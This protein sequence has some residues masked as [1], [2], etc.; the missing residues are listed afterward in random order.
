MGLVAWSGIRRRWVSLLFLTVALGLTGAVVLASVAGSRRGRES[1]DNFVEYYRPG[2]LQAFVDPGLPIDEQVDLLEAMIEASG[3]ADHAARAALVVYL[4]GPEGLDGPGSDGLVADAYVSGEP[5]STMRRDLVVDGEVPL[6]PG[7]AAIS[8]SL[9]RRRDL[10]VGDA[11][12]L[13]LFAPEDLD[14]VGGGTITEP[15]ESVEVT[16]GAV[17]RA[18]VDL[19]RSPQAQPGTIFEADESRIVLEPSFWADHGRASANY[20]LGATFDV[21]PAD[22]DAVS[23]AMTEAGGESSLVYPTGASDEEGRITPVNDAIALEANALLAFA[24]VVLVFGLALL[25]TALARAAGDDATDRRTLATLGLSRRQQVAMFLVRGGLVVAGA[26]VL[27]GAGAIAASSRFPIGLGGDAETDPGLDLDGSVLVLGGLAF[28]VLV[29]LRLLLGAWSD[30]RRLT[31]GRRASAPSALPLTPVGLGAR[32][33]TDGLGR[34]GGGTT[35]VALVTAVVGLAAVT[36]AATYG[37][38]LHRLVDSPERQGWTWDAV[39]GNYSG[40]PGAAEEGRAALEANPDVAAFTAYQTTTYLVDG[41]TVT[42]AEFEPGAIDLV[43]VVLEGRAPIADDEIAL[44]RGTLA[45]LGKERGDTVEVAATGQPVEATIVGVIVAPATIA[46]E[47]DLDSGGSIAF[48]L[49]ERVLADQPHN[50]VLGYLVDFVEGTD[51]AAA[52]QGLTEDFPGTVL[53]PMQP[54]DVANLQRVRAAPYLLA[55]LLGAMAVI[56]TVVTLATASRRR[57]RDVAVL[58]GLGLARGQLRRLLAGQA[59]TFLGLALVVGLPLG[60]VVG[61]LA[62]TLAADGLGSELRPAA[63][64][65]TIA[66]AATCVLVLVNLYAQGLAVVVGR[67][68]PG[69]DLRAE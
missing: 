5:F 50:S 43:P 11:L 36:A 10:S 68:K 48:P 3:P 13:A 25:G 7:E 62:W 27:A 67:R 6:D 40:A 30:R 53:G 49:V 21:A 9:A 44:G 47:M 2:N 29:A 16:V 41:Q 65:L 42:L 33:A 20:G 54:L 4:P 45:Q 34:R 17:T 66:T 52:R 58:R 59:T 35:R 64:V 14:R 32:L 15:R 69:E 38:S 51:L 19:A 23:Q 18:P 26:T 31:D 28:A 8:E 55:G 24:A 22:V 60:L 46:P 63:P 56:S 37:A 57:R 12:T 39:V 1:L 61:R